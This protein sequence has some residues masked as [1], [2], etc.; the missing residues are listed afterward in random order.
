MTPHLSLIAIA[1]LLF[2]STNLDDLLILVG[3]FADR[4]YLP[5]EIVIGQF[6]GVASLFA[7]SASASLFSIVIPLP[8]IGLLGI[9]PIVIGARKLWTLFQQQDARQEPLS[10]HVDG[11]RRGNIASV[12][13][14][15]IANGADNL[16]VY[17][18]WFAMRSRPELAAIG[19]VFAIMTTVWC[20]LAHAVVK[21]PLLAAPI[22][23]YGHRISPLILICLGFLILHRAGSFRL[24]HL[25]P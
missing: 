20:L 1:I 2:V 25:L 22:R 17:T 10:R 9:A 3:F 18:P 19:I 7:V 11:V 6:G 23:Q 16:A 12:A 4:G 13:I 8:Y 14:V 24:L 21:H 5:R 15:T